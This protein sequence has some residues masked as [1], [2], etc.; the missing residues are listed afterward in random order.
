MFTFSGL[1]AAWGFTGFK[2]YAY[3]KVYVSGFGGFGAFVL[4]VHGVDGLGVAVGVRR[5]RPNSF[6]HIQIQENERMSEARIQK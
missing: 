3:F 2:G 5:T 1:G 4:W 6:S